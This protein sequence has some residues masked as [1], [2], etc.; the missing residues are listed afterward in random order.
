MDVSLC[1]PE[2]KF[3][4]VHLE[5]VEG[6]PFSGWANFPGALPKVPS[7]TEN[8]TDLTFYVFFKKGP[9]LQI[10]LIFCFVFERLGD[11][12]WY[13][14][15][16][17]SAKEFSLGGQLGMSIRLQL[18]KVNTPSCGNILKWGRGGA[19][20]F[21]FSTHAFKCIARGSRIKRSEGAWQLQ[22]DVE[23]IRRLHA[24]VEQG[25]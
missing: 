13:P 3:T 4:I 23:G 22:V 11:M 17:A 8:Q 1:L 24:G 21:R 2:L 19:S 6:F 9:N 16:R 20:D 18:L 5:K 15:P 25:W 12:A 7:K 14:P 10:R